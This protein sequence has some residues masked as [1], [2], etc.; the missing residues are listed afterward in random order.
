MD[1]SMQALCFV[2]YIIHIIICNVIPLVNLNWKVT[3]N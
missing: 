1:V 3:E 2:Y